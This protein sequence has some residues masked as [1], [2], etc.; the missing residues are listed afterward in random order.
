MCRNIGVV[1]LLSF[2]FLPLFMFC[3]EVTHVCC[4]ISATSLSRD[5]DQFG[6]ENVADYFTEGHR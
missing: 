5:L 1:C 6:S 3:C 2:F 4:N